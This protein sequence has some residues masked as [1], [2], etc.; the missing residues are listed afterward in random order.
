MKKIKN[1]TYYHDILK[2]KELKI[3][4]IV[5]EAQMNSDSV[6]K[7]VNIMQ[8]IKERFQEKDYNN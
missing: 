1:N 5:E 7:K 4:L 6:A 2:F 8:A 3:T